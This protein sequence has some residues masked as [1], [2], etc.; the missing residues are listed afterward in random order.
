M[1]THTHRPV[2]RVRVPTNRAYSSAR[3]YG[4]PAPMDGLNE[5]VG[6][7]RTNRQVGARIERENVEHVARFVRAK[8]HAIGYAPMTE[9]DRQRA[10]VYVR[11]REPHDGRDVA[12]VLGGVLKYTLDALTARNKHGTGAIWDDSTKWI[13]KLVPQIV[14]DPENVGV[15]IVVIPLEEKS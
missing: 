5:I 11:I 8:M 1:T 10:V 2:L 12:N 14:V 6:Q 15:E 9:T 7:N 13:A 3:N 4:K